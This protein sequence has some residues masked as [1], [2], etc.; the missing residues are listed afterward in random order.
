[1][2]RVRAASPSAS[3][4]DDRRLILLR[5]AAFLAHDLVLQPVRPE[6]RR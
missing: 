6:I 4:S 1:M 2:V 3:R 5:P